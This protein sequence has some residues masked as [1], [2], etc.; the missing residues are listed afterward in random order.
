MQTKLRTEG[1]LV[2]DL[3]YLGKLASTGALPSHL[4]AR[5]ARRPGRWRAKMQP[6][7]RFEEVLVI[8]EAA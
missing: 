2:D 6:R 1:T 5:I 8:D 4:F 3:D 7:S